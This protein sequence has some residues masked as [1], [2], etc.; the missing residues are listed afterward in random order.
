[1]AIHK[2][3][4]YVQIVFTHPH[5]PKHTHTHPNTFTYTEYSLIFFLTKVTS[6][7]SV[8]RIMLQVADNWGR[9]TYREPEQQRPHQHDRGRVCDGS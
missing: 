8:G 2:T 5:T 1:M 9:I 7:R 6:W 3:H 4:A